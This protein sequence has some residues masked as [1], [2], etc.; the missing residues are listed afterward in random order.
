[1]LFN[2]YVYIFL[3]LP[4]AVAVYFLLNRFKLVTAGKSWLVAASLFF[5]SYWNPEYSLL[6]IFS[7][8]INFGFGSV[9]QKSGVDEKTKS[10]TLLIGLIVNLGLLCWF[11][12][13]DFLVFNLNNLLGFSIPL[14]GVVLPLAISFFSFQQ[15]A[16]LVD[17]RRG[18]VKER[19]FLDYTLF[20]TFFP[21]LI[22]GPI[23]HHAEMMPQFS[24]IGK[25]RFDWQNVAP[26]LTLFAIGLFKK[27][28]IADRLA[29]AVARGFDY[30]LPLDLV[31][32]W[33]ASLSYTFQIYFDFS[34]Y[35]DMALG[36]ALM[37]NIWLPRNFNSPYQ[38][39]SIQDFWR[40]WHMTLSRFLSSYLYIPLGGN[41]IS[42]PVTCRNLFITFL[43]GGIWHGAGWTFI[44]WGVLHGIG[45]IVNR[46]WSRLGR[47][48][49][50][51]LAWL[52]TFGFVNVTWVFFRA[53]SFD[54][55]LRL[56][57]G[58]IGL[59]GVALPKWMDIPLLA[60]LGIV[61]DSP[62]KRFQNPDLVI[63]MLA[64]CALCCLL[65]KNSNTLTEEFRPTLPR[66]AMAVAMA[67]AGIVFVGSPSEF[68]YFQF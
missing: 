21:Q 7:V 14:P 40:R 10:L 37:F 38:A 31:G 64:G 13:S 16:Y 23:V 51:A 9:L 24:D 3:F 45:M 42:L 30:H 47:Q 29:T 66:L 63:P 48:L 15:V 67:V 32:S 12:Y 56:L 44:A 11:K 60:N 1:M 18:I 17:S 33:V 28:I 68:I 6:I 27:V 49:P 43:L 46:L 5:Y 19:K 53:H 41:R 26:G 8:L 65:L 57:G 52:L 50:K 62:I 36:A 22:A 2:S 58:M 20:V 25:K 39:L 35:T 4:V 54:D 61:F 34:G 55:A 59:N